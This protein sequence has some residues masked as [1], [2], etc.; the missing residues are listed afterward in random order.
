M[1]F[2]MRS[3]GRALTA[4]LFVAAFVA[5]AQAGTVIKLTLDDLGQAPTD[6]DLSW[7]GGSFQ[8]IND[9]IAATTG[10]QNTTIDFVGDLSGMA[11]IAAGGSFSITGVDAVGP[12]MA[13]GSL[14][15]QSTMGGTISLY[16]ADNSLLL[17]ATINEGTL[18]GST[19]GT[20]G[21]FFS[22]DS[23]TIT[24]GS[25]LSELLPSPAAIS[26]AM[27]EVTSAGGAA[28]MRVVAG[29]LQDFTANATINIDALVPAP[30]AA[31]L[32]AG[33]LLVASRRRRA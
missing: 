13:F 26:I 3:A 15:I 5:S 33:G 21:S 16:A 32:L 2:P 20:A 1:T 10:H 25:L 11:D 14:A 9:G 27:T 8:T 29:S 22:I 30:G 31:G 18:T 4:G 17:Q 19:V 23:M 28:G 24:A 12:A 6:P 7:T